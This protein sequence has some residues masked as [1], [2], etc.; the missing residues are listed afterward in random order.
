MCSAGKFHWQDNLNMA[1]PTKQ[2]TG[3]KHLDTYRCMCECVCVGIVSM[4]RRYL[5]IVGKSLGHMQI[6]GH[7]AACCCRRRQMM[8]MMVGM[9]MW[10]RVR[11]RMMMWMR[12]RM[13]VRMRVR[14]AVHRM[15]MMGRRHILDM[16]RSSCSRKARIGGHRV[17]AEHRGPRRGDKSAA[18]V[19]HGTI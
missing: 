16:R 14:M 5:P 7:A 17:V 10:M 18:M 11:M 3:D 2:K 15:R 4:L 19:L 1:T 8:M 6:H 13:R 9:R 12:M